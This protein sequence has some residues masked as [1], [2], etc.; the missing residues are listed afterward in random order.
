MRIVF[1]D[2]FH[3]RALRTPKEVRTA[4]VYVLLNARRHGIPVAAPDPYSSGPWFRRVEG[5]GAG[6]F[7]D[8]VQRH[9]HGRSPRDHSI[10]ETLSRRRS[11]TRRSRPRGA[12][13]SPK[14][15]SGM[16]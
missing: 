9:G 1:A 13:C 11:G 5:V 10:A 2:R 7:S 16:A 14:A 3:A 12:G 6:G 8:S 4:L 15:G